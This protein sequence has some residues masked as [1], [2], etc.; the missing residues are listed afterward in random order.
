VAKKGARSP[1][2]TRKQLTPDRKDLVERIFNGVRTPI[3]ALSLI[4]EG[5]PRIVDCNQAALKLIGYEKSEIVDKSVQFLN[6]ESHSKGDLWRPLRDAGKRSFD[7]VGHE[8]KRKDGTVFLADLKVSPLLNGKGKQVG[9]ITVVNDLTQR[10]KMEAKR[11]RYEDRLAALHRH[12]VQLSSATTIESVADFTLGAIQ[13]AL[14]MRNV[15]FNLVEQNRVRMFKSLGTPLKDGSIEFPRC[16]S[17]GVVVRAA[18]TRKSLLIP[19]TRNEPSFVD[20]RILDPTKEALH[21]LSELAAPVLVDGEAVAV[22]NVESETLNAFSGEDQKYLEV[23]AFQTGSALKR[24]WYEEKLTTLHNHALKL[25][26]ASTIDEIVTY[27][28][29]AMEFALRFDHSDV[30]VV[31]DGWL[32]C[33]GARGMQMINADLRLDGSGITVKATNSR[34]TIRVADTRK[35]PSYIDRIHDKGSDS[36]TMLS[37]LAVPVVVNDMTIAVLNVE[38]SKANA[39]KDSDQTLLEILT[40]HVASAMERISNL[41]S[42]RDSEDRYRTLF[43]NA[44]DAIFIHDLGGRFLEVNELACERLRYSRDELLKMTPADIDIAEH[45][46]TVQQRV[47][48]LEKSG[49]H[50]AEIVQVR[51]DGS[52]IPTELSSRIIEFKGQPAVLSIARDITERKKMEEELRSTKKRLDD[53]IQSNPAVIYSGKP[54]TNFSGWEVT[55]VSDRVVSMLGYESNEIVGHPDFW[56]SHV[57]PDDLQVSP[58][59]VRALWEEGHRAF[60][61]RFQHKDGSYRWIREEATVARDVDSKP[62]EVNGYWTDITELK[63]MQLR[64]LKDEHLAAI[65]AVVYGSPIPQFVVDRDHRVI[66]WNRALEEI[67]EIKEDEVRGTNQQ[68]RAFYDGVRPCL[69]DLLLDGNIELIHQLYGE[70]CKNSRLVTDALEATDYF[71][72]LGKQGRWLHFTAAIT[73]DDKGNVTGGVETLQDITELELKKPTEKSVQGTSARIASQA[74]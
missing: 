74:Q 68:W 22:L 10:N 61:Y 2:V 30:R 52:T 9:S 42:L 48:D 24:L 25:N 29:D 51:H 20:A 53:V 32:R 13:E 47:E 12:S 50:Y 14:D 35:E 45:S 1:T 43:H 64:L 33:K 28:L 54:L 62:L 56:N 17:S 16:G 72:R 63:E 19:D 39:I 67:T 5:P 41:T 58:M 44:S 65:A 37:E 8:L 57:H 18:I 23:I 59:T 38:S 3:L 15:D 7:I 55:F 27:T 60:E 73:K 6:S 34:R 26:V 11:L 70:K 4:Q 69:V 21:T 40:T 31:Q 49:H 46:A 71:P 66:S 36:P